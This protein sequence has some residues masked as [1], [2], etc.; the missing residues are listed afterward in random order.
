MGWET[1]FTV[2][3]EMRNSLN[4]ISVMFWLALLQY[5]CWTTCCI[6]SH[7]TGSSLSVWVM[8]IMGIGLES[9]EWYFAISSPSKQ[10][11]QWEFSC[12]Y[13]HIL[14]YRFIG[15]FSPISQTV[16]DEI[17]PLFLPSQDYYSYS[18]CSFL[19]IAGKIHSREQT[20]SREH[21]IKAYYM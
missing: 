9:W 12:I 8:L 10:S 17:I 14:T 18:Q 11:F 19:N 13:T 2:A 6:I 3:P 20:L 16:S 15:L 5:D 21:L 1:L 4:N 7:S